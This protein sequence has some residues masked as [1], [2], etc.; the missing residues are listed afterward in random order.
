MN[1]ESSRFWIDY[2]RIFA[3]VTVEGFVDD[4]FIDNVDVVMSSLATIEVVI[5]NWCCY[6]LLK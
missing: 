3:N 6:H 5:R 1:D 4:Y 2:R